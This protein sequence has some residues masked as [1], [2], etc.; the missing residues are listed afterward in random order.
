M[1]Q[2]QDPALIR[3]L[4]AAS[5]AGVPITLNIRGLCCLRPGVSG[6][7]ENVRVYSVLGRF[8]EH[9]RIYCFTNGGAPEYYIGSA[10]WMKRN[11]D[12]R[13][14]TVAPVW[15]PALQ[16]ELRAILD[17]YDADNTTAWDL[18]PDGT[19]VRRT[20][21]EGDPERSSQDVFERLARGGAAPERGAGPGNGEAA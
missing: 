2:L 18:R 5:H 13:V 19:Y 4:Y 10:D 9:A 11:L 21:S 6:L 1:N 7:S 20:P 12:N 14:E 3:E 17:V 8:L 16:E 15:D